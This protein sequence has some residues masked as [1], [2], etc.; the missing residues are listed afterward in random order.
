MAMLPDEGIRE[1][2]QDIAGLVVHILSPNP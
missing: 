1:P 2:D